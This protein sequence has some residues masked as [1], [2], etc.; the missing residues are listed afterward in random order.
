M[1]R[2]ASLKGRPIEKWDQEDLR[3]RMP[4]RASLKG[5]PIEKWDQ[6]DLRSRMPRRA[7]LFKNERGPP[8]ELPFRESREKLKM[9]EQKRGKEA[10]DELPFRE[11][12]EKL[13]MDEQKRGNEAQDELRMVGEHIPLTGQEEMKDGKE[14]QEELRMARE[15]IPSTVRLN[16]KEG[17]E[18]MRAAMH[19]SISHGPATNPYNEEENELQRKMDQ[20]LKQTQPNPSFPKSGFNPPPI[21]KN[22]F[23]PPLI[24]KS[25]FNPPPIPPL[26]PL[27]Y[28]ENEH[29]LEPTQGKKPQGF[30]PMLQTMLRNLGSQPG[31]GVG[32]NLGVHIKDYDPEKDPYFGEINRQLMKQEKK[33]RA[34][35]HKK[36]SEEKD[37]ENEG[38]SKKESA[39]E[40]ALLK[41]GGSLI[42]PSGDAENPYR[43][44]PQFY[45]ETQLPAPFAEAA[46]RGYKDS[47]RGTRRLLIDR[48][49]DE[50]EK[51]KMWSGFVFCVRYDV[52]EDKM[53]SL[54]VVVPDTMEMNQDE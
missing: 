11:S 37:K 24:P 43:F 14:A 45:P 39:M 50:I 44:N 51:C 30:M 22:G 5:R 36:K 6:E 18:E 8:P 17:Q 52:K 34:H 16:N 19:K 40:K 2:R 20:M 47:E 38:K 3:S 10:H 28:E 21:P 15:H 31:E 48:A 25:G 35:V 54:D 41:H 53:K 32:G 42:P 4:R 9:D 46:H 7:S 26:P 29:E 12:R 27:P 23:N 1:P 33:V 49:Y 13:K